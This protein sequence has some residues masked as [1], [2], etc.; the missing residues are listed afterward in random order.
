MA[1]DQAGEVELQE[2]ELKEVKE[3]RVLRGYT[4]K[5]SMASPWQVGL[6]FDSWWYSFIDTRLSLDLP[7]KTTLGAVQVAYTLEVA[8]FS[9]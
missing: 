7:R 8:T 9:F 4:A 1:D 3:P 5:L 2:L 6:G